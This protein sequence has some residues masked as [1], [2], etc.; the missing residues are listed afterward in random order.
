MKRTQMKPKPKLCKVCK[1]EFMPF[2][3]TQKVCGIGCAIHRAR[4]E[5]IKRQDKAHAK[6]KKEFKDND[7]PH[8]KT[9]TQTAFNKMRKLQELVC[10]KEAGIEPYCISCLKTNMD[11]CCGHYQTV[12]SQGIL[13]YDIR[14]TYLQC[15]RY[16]NM[17]LSGNISGNKNTIGYVKGIVHRFGDIEGAEILEYCETTNQAK[18]WTCEEV[19]AIRMDAFKQI[20]ILEKRLAS[21]D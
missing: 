14:N 3:S 18:T 16:C 6:K 9:L 10:F 5:E 12:G 2:Q 4:E 7:L 1:T 8:Q 13:R 20:K 17:G 19:M 21:D 11:W 15:N